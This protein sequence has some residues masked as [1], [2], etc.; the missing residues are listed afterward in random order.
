MHK[1]KSI[2][3][4]AALLLCAVYTAVALAESTL[5]GLWD[6][7]CNFLY[8]TDNVTVTGEASFSLGGE[9]F[10]TAQ[11]QY[12]QDGYS[13]YY[14]LKLLTPKADGTER[15]TG[16][17]VIADEE[18]SYYVMEAFFPGTYRCGIG[19]AHN[20]LLRRTVQLDA[21]TE[22]G[23]LIVAQVEPLLPEGVITATETEEAKTVHIALTRDQL[24]DIAASALNLAANYLCDRWFAYEN[25]HTVLPEENPSFDSYV[26]PTQAL[27]NGTVSWALQSADVD[28]TL[29][30]Q[31]RLTAVQGTVR[32]ASTYWDG[33]VREVEVTFSLAV[34]DYGTSRVKPFDPADYGVELMEVVFGGEEDSGFIPLDEEQ[35]DAMMAKAEALILSQGYTVN[36]DA[37][38]GGWN[39]SDHIEVV[40]DNLDGVEYDF[41]FAEDGSVLLMQA[42]NESWYYGNETEPEGIDE[43]TKAD[44][45]SKIR[46]FAAD[47]APS[48]A[49]KL[50]EL[51]LMSMVKAEDGSVYLTFA[52]AEQEA[53]FFLVQVA[54]EVRIAHFS[55]IEW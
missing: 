13:S 21:L 42:F 9:H 39:F 18:G 29:D 23:G 31:N 16:W 25:E 28:F 10:K 12:I 36:P 7:G 27:A 4:L 55:L 6:S 26:T 38:R 8:H 1:K 54:P 3:L 35:W 48:L 44:A 15:E 20:T 47:Y 41:S 46:A 49:D 22:L 40:I 33:T 2:L 43:Q 30:A 45:E 50:T 17:T 19:T 51:T 34:S 14:G 37:S 5:A 32:A 24:P 11:L 52:D 53:A